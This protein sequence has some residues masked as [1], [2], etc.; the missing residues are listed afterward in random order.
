MKHRKRTPRIE[1]SALLPQHSA[2]GWARAL[3]K[4]SLGLSAIVFVLVAI[5]TVVQGQ[6]PA[7]VPRI[8]LL[9]ASSPSAMAPRIDAFRQGLRDLGYVEG[10]NIVIERRYAEGKSE[11]LPALAAELV[12]L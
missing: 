11:H 9:I 10:K 2:L 6:Q 5:G 3:T 12:R 4:N 1:Y 8:G 7:K